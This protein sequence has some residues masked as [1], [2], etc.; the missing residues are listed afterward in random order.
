M[1]NTN[2]EKKDIRLIGLDLDG[3]TLT[4]DKV[5]TPHTKEVLEACLKQGIQILPATGRVR[6]GIPAYLTEIE[7]IRYVVASNGAAIVDLQTGENVYSN[8]ISWERA[9]ELF[10]ILEK[11]QTFYDIYALGKGWCEARFYDHLDQFN[12]E[13]H[14][15]QLIRV[16]RTKIDNLRIWM[17][18][19][20]APV[21]KINMFFA[22]E[23]DRQKAFSELNQIPD[24][25][26]TFSLVNNLEINYS[27][28]NKGDAL[29]NLGKI[30]HISFDQ[31]MACG[32][33]NNDYEMIKRAGVGVA[34][35]NGE[36][37]LKEIADF[38]TKSNDEEGV[39]YAIE[40]FCDLQL[41]K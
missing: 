14:I 7:G 13:P 26:V 6:S 1:K 33:G 16:S 34:M 15:Q 38:I 35:E 31:I 11:Y 41:K 12:I 40:E 4:S 3:T 2:N 29:M 30:L 36:E 25:S 8:C 28:C 17:R 37:S 18:E 32:D 27:T 21:E 20:K 10:D 24:L 9:L 23:E 5:L 19:H 22:K 39:A